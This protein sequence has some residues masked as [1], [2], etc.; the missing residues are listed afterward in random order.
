MVK[1]IQNVPKLRFEGFID[2]WEQR[3]V[4]DIADRFDNLRIPIASNLRVPGSVPYYG[5]NGIQDFVEGYTHDGENV[6]I[7][8][9]GAN[10]FKNYPVRYVIGKIWVNNH[11]HVLKGKQGELDNLFFSFSLNQVD[12]ESILV[13][14][15]RA[16]LNT[17]TM[18]NISITMPKMKEQL[19][20]GKLLYHVDNLITL[21]QR[22]LS[23]FQDLKKALLVKMF[24][25]EGESIPA[26][27]FKGFGDDWEQHTVGELCQIS[28]GK[29][30]TQDACP[31]GTYPFYVRSPIVER[32]TRF[33]YDEEAVLTV[34]DGVGTGK[35]FHYV[36]GKY[37]LHQRVYRIYDFQNELDGNFF[38]YLFSRDFYNRIMMMSAKTSVDSVRYEMIA[39]MVI[40]IPDINEQRV[41]A[42]T[43]NS[44]NT[45]IVIHQRKLDKLKDI[46]KALLNNMF[47]GGD[48]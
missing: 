28:T 7:A 12:F 6:L 41:I 9:D 17:E 21:H 39:D 33:L 31:D 48:I 25:V 26:V 19:R 27:R 1:D 16:K 11:A 5:A 8:E 22:K 37:D 10:D 3:K 44:I 43:L 47:P 45:S 18:M 32:S 42:A 20:I 4:G 23:K 2:A 13:G 38:Y 15:S 34:G 40:K 24:P 14:G 29:S 35:V 30:N 36:N 46:K